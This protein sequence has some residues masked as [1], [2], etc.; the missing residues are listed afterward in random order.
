MTIFAVIVLLPGVIAGTMQH[1]A[2]FTATGWTVEH[3]INFGGIDRDH[4]DRF[5]LGPGVWQ[6]TDVSIGVRW[7]GIGT[8][9]MNI[10]ILE[11]DGNRPGSVVLATARVE[12][13][14]IGAFETAPLDTPVVLTAGVYW[15]AVSSDPFSISWWR[16]SGTA[17]PTWHAQRVNLG[18]WFTIDGATPGAFMIHGSQISPSP[19]G[20]G[21]LLAAAT[22]RPRRRRRG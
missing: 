20:L 13:E 22:L 7:Q 18:N 15:L 10:A 8:R 2:D 1:E 4:A 17:N 3:G 16:L 9:A 5:A 21:V 12:W 14:G 19:G 6:V 11:N